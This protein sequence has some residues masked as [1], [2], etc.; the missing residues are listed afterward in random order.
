MIEIQ[1]TAYN[2]TSIRN[3]DPMPTCVY[4]T[5]DTSSMIRTVIIN[6]YIVILLIDSWLKSYKNKKYIVILLTTFP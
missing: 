6:Q 1:D 3:G 4:S 2:G 5:Q